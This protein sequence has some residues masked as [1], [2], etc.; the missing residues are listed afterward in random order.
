MA[1]SGGGGD[2]GQAGAHGEESETARASSP[3]AIA[4]TTLPCCSSPSSTFPR[5][6]TTGTVHRPANRESSAW[7]GFVAFRMFFARFAAS[8]P[9]SPTAWSW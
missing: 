1:F 3:D 2:E 7:S 6:T 4:S 5:T 8:D 9:S